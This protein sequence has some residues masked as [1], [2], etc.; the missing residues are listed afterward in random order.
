MLL[1]H[2][3][4]YTVSGSTVV[5]APGT[6]PVAG[7]RLDAWYRLASTGTSEINFADGEVPVGTVDGV[8][9]MFLLAGSPLPASSLRVYR[10][11]LLQKPGVDYN[12]MVNTIVFTAVSVPTAGDILQAW[13][14]F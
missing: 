1:R 2:G 5:L 3:T 12:L 7:D 6:A 11:G 10:N 14:R 8:N 4:D 13:Y 9:T